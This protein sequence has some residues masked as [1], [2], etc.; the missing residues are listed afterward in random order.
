LL[1]VCDA[2]DDPSCFRERFFCLVARRSTRVERDHLIARGLGS[3]GYTLTDALREVEVR[4]L[5]A[6]LRE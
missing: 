6:M 1:H 3:F 5:D 2:L 4:M